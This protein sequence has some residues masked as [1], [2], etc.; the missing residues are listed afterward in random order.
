MNY[1]AE[2][3]HLMPEA[4]YYNGIEPVDSLPKNGAT[5]KKN[6]HCNHFKISLNNYFRL[7][8]AGNL[9]LQALRFIKHVYISISL[10]LEIA[11][12]PIIEN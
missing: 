6:F 11:I 2:S 5:K 10:I 1:D 3:I 8:H 7:F 12:S 9:F 4:I